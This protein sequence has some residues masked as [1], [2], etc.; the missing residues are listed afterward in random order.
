MGLTASCFQ[1]GGPADGY[2]LRVV[3]MRLGSFEGGLEFLGLTDSLFFSFLTSRLQLG[4]SACCFLFRRLPGFECRGERGFQFPG[5]PLRFQL[6]RASR[7]FQFPGPAR[8]FLLG[9]LSGE[10]GRCQGGLDLRGPPLRFFFGELAAVLGFLDPVGRLLLR[11]DTRRFL[12]PAALRFLLGYLPGRSGLLGLPGGLFFGGLSGGFLFGNAPGCVG[13]GGPESLLELGR[14]LFG[15]A[16]RVSKLLEIRREPIG[17]FLGL[18][19]HSLGFA[20]R[21]LGFAGLIL[22]LTSL[23]LRLFG[24]RLF[25]LFLFELGGALGGLLGRDTS[26]LQLGRSAGRFLFRLLR[27][28]LG[29]LTLLSELRGRP[30]RGRHDGP[31]RDLLGEWS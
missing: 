20:G 15:L 10:L 12:P 4:R 16:R 13:F 27:S 1:F 17:L 9:F 14:T 19:G 18:L 22:G 8:S 21:V 25:S 6:G 3:S 26:L 2:G 30:A 29:F 5:V 31:P 11:S 28:L 7:G 24:L 23:G